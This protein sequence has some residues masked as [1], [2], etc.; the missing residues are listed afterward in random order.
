MLKILPELSLFLLLSAA[1]A[2]VS[3]AINPNGLV[4]NFDYRSGLQDSGTPSDLN[5]E[6]AEPQSG[7]A[8]IQAKAQEYGFQLSGPEDVQALLEEASQ[9]EAI[10]ILDART[11]QAFADGHLPGAVRLD[12]WEVVKQG[13]DPAI[14]ARLQQAFVVL[15]YCNGGDCEDS[16]NLAFYLS[17]QNPDLVASPELIHIFTGGMEAW[18]QLNQKDPQGYAIER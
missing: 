4:L 15:I 12:Y 17:Y 2:L 1:A 16:F 14:Q 9:E 5:Q 8:L 3:N 18:R 7:E 10:L 11:A 13:V 6:S